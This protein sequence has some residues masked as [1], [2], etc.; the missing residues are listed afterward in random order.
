MRSAAMKAKAVG[1]KQ[2]APATPTEDNTSWVTLGVTNEDHKSEGKG[3]RIRCRTL[4]AKSKGGSAEYS[5]E[6]GTVVLFK[7]F[8]KEFKKL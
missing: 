1:R 3:N 8:V 6:G 4:A 5:I 7:V 2:S